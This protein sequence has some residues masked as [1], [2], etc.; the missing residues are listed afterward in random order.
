ICE[1]ACGLIAETDAGGGGTLSPDVEHVVSR[2][3]ACAKGV[4]FGQV[5][6]DPARVNAPHL[7]RGGKLERASWPEAL[8]RVGAQLRDIREAHGSHAVGVYLGNPAAFSPLTPLFGTAFVRG[9]GTRNYFNAGSLDCNNKFVV[10]REM[11]GSPG[12][13]PVPDLDRA[14]FALLL[15]TNPSVS[16]SSFINAPRMVERLRKIEKRGGRVVVVDPRRTETAQSVGEWLPIRPGGDAALLLGLIHVILKEGRE[17]KIRVGRFTR[18]V[19]DLRRHVAAFDPRRVASL[20]GIEPARLEALARDFAAADG[21]FCHLSTGVN[22][23]PH[24]TLAYA[25]KIALE[26]IT[27]NLDRE[28][29]AL[30]PRGAID[31]ATWARRLGIDREPPWRSRVGGFPPVLGALPCSILPDEILTRGPDQIRALVVI[32]G[33]PLLSA[34]DGG[35]LLEAFRSLELLV[36][37]DLFINDTGALAHAVLPATDWLEREDMPL[38]Q[39]QLQPEPY[40][41]WSPAVTPAHG[42]RRHDWQILLELARHGGFPLGSPALQRGLELALKWMGPSRLLAAPLAASLGPRPLELLKR[43]PHGLRLPQTPAGDFLRRRIGTRSRRV[44]LCPESVFSDA[45]RVLAD[46]PREGTLLLF[47]KR[48]RV[49]HNS[50]MHNNSE[51]RPAPQR[52]HLS[53]EDASELGLANGDRV[54]LRSETGVIELRVQ[55]DSDVAPGGVAVPH[56]YGHHR[57]S[58]WSL[59]R[60]RGGANV[61][62]LAASGPRAAH[63]LSGMSQFN[64]LEVRI[65]K[66]VGDEAEGSGDAAGV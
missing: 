17:H 47:S 46:V 25:A 64:A 52:A 39:L 30:F 59:A 58:S 8:S 35:R 60:T 51:L 37:I 27:G 29:G 15:G 9:L 12:I 32:A 7:R 62:A 26:T 63:P 6:R 3:F 20:T 49:G 41:Q 24:G 65:E 18:G 10:A 53:P 38:A 22:Q 33:N 2:G 66:L 40:L 4:R 56:G 48:Q 44:E 21:A 55:L 31:V 57:D 11:L 16:Q 14:R 54:R 61:N 19:D 45:P 1:A 43:H 23:G 34:A 50:W 28:G 42:E 36:V 5:H 13:H